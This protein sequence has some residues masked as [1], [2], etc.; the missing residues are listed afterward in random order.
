MHL[1]NN[2]DWTAQHIQREYTSTQSAAAEYPDLDPNS[3]SPDSRF[4]HVQQVQER[5]NFLRFL[6]KDGQLWLCAPQAKQLMGEEPDLDPEINKDFFEGIVLQL[7][8]CLLTESGIRC[9]DRFFK[10]VN[11]KESKLIAKRR[12][13]LMNDLELL[14]LDYLWRLMS[15]QQG[16]AQFLFQLADL[17][18]NLNVPA[19]RDE[20]HAVLKL[21]PPGL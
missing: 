9:F 21:M 15:Q 4:S 3:V 16:Y 7:D 13:Y 1:T 19:L 11:S 17:G 10:A 14:G 8:P 12:A 6:L 2:K 18:S 5:L 20:A